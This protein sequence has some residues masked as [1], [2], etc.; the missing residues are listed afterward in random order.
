MKKAQLG[1]KGMIE[2]CTVS[3]LT[4]KIEISSKCLIMYQKR[5]HILDTL[6]KIICTIS[7][8]SKM[9]SKKRIQEKKERKMY[10]NTHTS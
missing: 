3:A 9:F 6:K 2:Y 1:K 8:K 7:R 4:V 10:S 5:Y